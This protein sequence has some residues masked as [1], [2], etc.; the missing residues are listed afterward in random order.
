V[1]LFRARV[2]EKR[3]CRGL[4]LQFID[5]V[6]FSCY[7]GAK[8]IPDTRKAEAIR[9]SPCGA[10]AAGRVME[11]GKQV[12]FQTRY[13]QGGWVCPLFVFWRWIGYYQGFSDQ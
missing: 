8:V 1:L 3:F 7:N 10:F 5:A 9:F 13:Q 11:P 12:I 2:K 6:S 4:M